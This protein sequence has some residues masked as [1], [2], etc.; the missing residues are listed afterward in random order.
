MDKISAESMK[1][2]ADVALAT[3]W[4]LASNGFKDL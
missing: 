4:R 1:T 2:A 3:A